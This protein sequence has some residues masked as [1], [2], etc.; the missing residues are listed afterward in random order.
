MQT[1]AP[2]IRVLLIADIRLYREGLAGVLE[3]VDGMTVV[4]V[5][6]DPATALQAALDCGPDVIVV[7]AAM[8]AARDALRELASASSARLVALDVPATEAA[9]V[10]YA[11]S[12]V[13]G[14]ITRDGSLDDVVRTIRAA[15]SGDVSCEPVLMARLV[16]GIRSAAVC[17]RDE[18]RPPS[19]ASEDR[20]TARELQIADLIAFEGLSNREIAARLVTELPTVKNHVHN[21]LAK[22]GVTRRG[23]VATRLRTREPVRT[24]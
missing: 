21:I 7:D 13:V 19:S 1:H 15:C 2:L 11:E 5:A 6:D 8:V 10:E 23:Q 22:L 24:I 20:L 12:G 16:H 3:R 18:A 9:M 14:Y 17:A 4:A